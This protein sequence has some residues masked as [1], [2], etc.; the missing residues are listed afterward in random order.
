MATTL[1]VFAHLDDRFV[2]AGLLS[3]PEKGTELLTSSLTRQDALE[4]IDRI[5]CVVRKWKVRF[6]GYGVAGRQIEVIA[7]A[8]RQKML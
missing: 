2:P 4:I 8:F 5:W 3:M 1:A 6:E 7:S